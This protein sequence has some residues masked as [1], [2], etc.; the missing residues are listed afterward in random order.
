MSKPHNGTLIR[1]RM[2]DGSTSAARIDLK[3]RL[4]VEY[5]ANGMVE[6]V[7]VRQDMVAPFMVHVDD[8][9]SHNQAQAERD[10]AWRIS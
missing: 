2:E 8:I 1:Y 10:A 6:W 4:P 9:V 7:P 3:S 5:D